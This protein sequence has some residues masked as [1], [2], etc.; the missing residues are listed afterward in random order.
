MK[1]Y[2]WTPAQDITCNDAICA[3]AIAVIKNN[4]CFMVKATNVYGCSGSDTICVKVFCQNSQVFIPNAFVPLGNVPENRILMVRASGI[5]SVK[6]FRVFNRW[7]KVVF[8]RNNFPPN[9]SDFGWDGRVNGKMADTGVYI[10]TVDVMCENGVPYSYKGNV[11][12][13]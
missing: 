4:V 12:L 13:L 2:T 3:S 6:T 1:Q 9:S 10:Y 11:T 8:E 7:G 5:A